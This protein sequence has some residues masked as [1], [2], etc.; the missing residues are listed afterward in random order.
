VNV[1]AA[2]VF[3]VSYRGSI[4]NVELLGSYDEPLSAQIRARKPVP[5]IGEG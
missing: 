1:L 3:D 5:Q 4:W 2:K